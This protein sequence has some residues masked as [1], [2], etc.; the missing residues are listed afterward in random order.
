MRLN[1]LLIIMAIMYSACIYGQNISP[2]R[3]GDYSP[4]LDSLITALLAD[5]DSSEIKS[6]MLGLQNFGS[7]FIIHENHQ[8]VALWVKNQFTEMGYETARID[9]F[10]THAQMSSLNIDTTVT[11][12]NVSAVLEGISDTV[13]IVGAHYDSFNAYSHPADSAPGADDNA[14]GTAAVL[15][16]ARVFKQHQVQPYYTIIFVAFDAEELKYYSTMNGARAFADMMVGQDTHVH[17]MLNYD[18]IANDDTGEKKMFAHRAYEG[19][20]NHNWHVEMTRPLAEK[21]TDLKV[22]YDSPPGRD[23]K[24]DDKPF[25][26][27]GFH[28]NYFEEYD[29]S[30]N[31][32]RNSDV[33][34]NCEM[35]YATDVARLGVASFVHAAYWPNPVRNLKVIN[36]GD[37]AQIDLSWCPSTSKVKNYTVQYRLHSAEEWEEIS[38]SDTS[39][40]LSDLITDSLYNIRVMSN[41]GNHL[42]SFSRVRQER[43]VD[44]QLD[45]GVLIINS[46]KENLTGIGRDSINRYYEH[47]ATPF[48]IESM[49]VDSAEQ[50]DENMLS[51]Y[52]T[53]IWHH[54]NS[55]SHL[56]FSNSSMDDFES[57]LDWGGHLL[58]SLYRPTR[59]F[60]NPEEAEYKFG[61]NHFARNI[62]HIDSTENR[63]PKVFHY[64]SP[65]ENKFSEMGVDTNKISDGYLMNIEAMHATA[66]GEIL[67]TYGSEFDSTSPV[68]SYHGKPVAISNRGEDIN[69]VTTSVPLYYLTTDSAK[70]FVHEILRNKFGEY[71]V[72]IPERNIEEDKQ[73][74]VYP[75]PACYELTFSWALDVSGWLKLKIFDMRGVELIRKARDPLYRSQQLSVNVSQLSPGIYAYSLSIG[76]HYYS[77]KFQ[78]SR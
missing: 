38:V 73:I 50:V 60:E 7:R 23:I 36:K 13:V 53:V 66:D 78:V 8:D 17:Y 32:H 56:H 20:E 22:I 26:D 15:E 68:G 16:M 42:G 35:A 57:Y 71:Y 52:S 72:G 51:R 54:E 18:M 24:T 43:P 19:K 67:Y 39:V 74:T 5:V 48:V 12:Y 3:S 31:Y 2:Q 28:T 21:Y 29:F 46:A 6:T 58:F 37:G 4:H 1:I 27:Y 59:F 65:L 63:Y 76:N 34:K 41:L 25:S 14:S 64:M 10:E 55:S 45:Q 62:L 75:N 44:A 9:E 47:L 11:C 69:V 61:K 33:V 49:N 70:T 77:G 30:P 40:T